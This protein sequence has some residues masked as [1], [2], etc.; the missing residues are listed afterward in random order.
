MRRTS[1]LHQ[2]HPYIRCTVA[3]LAP[4]AVEHC[5]PCT[6]HQM[7]TLRARN[8]AVVGEGLVVCRCRVDAVPF[9]CAGVDHVPRLVTRRTVVA[10]R[11]IRQVNNPMPVCAFQ[12][13]V[14]VDKKRKLVR[15]R[16]LSIEVV[17]DAR[18]GRCLV[19]AVLR[20]CAT[21]V[22]IKKR[23]EET[24]GALHASQWSVVVQSPITKT[25]H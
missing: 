14:V 2:Q 13:G 23:C 12:K 5:T 9:R 21:L 4:I 7:Q 6:L 10:A 16:A 19:D 1:H 3:P 24:I 15:L 8:N 25:R 20:V 18:Q 22:T 17:V 11:R